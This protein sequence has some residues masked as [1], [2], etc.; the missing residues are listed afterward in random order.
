MI[1]LDPK[2]TTETMESNDILE[3]EEEGGRESND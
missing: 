1:D 3:L 2:Y